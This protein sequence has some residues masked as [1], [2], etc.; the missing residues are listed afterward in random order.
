MDDVKALTGA[1][2]RAFDDDP[3]AVY[4]FGRPGARRRGLRAFF[5]IQLRRLL[6][7][8]G[9]VWTTDE[10]RA[11]AMWVPADMPAQVQAGVRDALR[12]APVLLDLVAGGAPG[13]A[14]RLL[15]EIERARPTVPHWYLATLGTDPPLQGHGV[16]SAL[17]RAVL[18]TVDSQ[19]APAYLE[20]SKERNVPFYARHGFEVTGTLR[21]PDGGVTLWLMWRRP[22]PPAC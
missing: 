8:A 14:L 2:V 19:G 18:R 20:S 17:L 16:G 9:E 10:R 21:P 22:H 12:L 5:D 6:R 15:A 11:A 1:L 7:G 4:L 13:P 3:V